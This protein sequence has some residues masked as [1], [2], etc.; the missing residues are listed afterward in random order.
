MLEKVKHILTFDKTVQ[1]VG[2]TFGATNAFR[3]LQVSHKENQLIYKELQS[4]NDEND[5]FEV[6]DKRKPVLLAFS[7]KGVLSKKMQRVPDYRSKVVMNVDVSEFYYYEWNGAKDVFV[8][9]CRK[10]VVNEH[11]ARFKKAGYLVVDYSIGPFVGAVLEPLIEEEKIPVLNSVL[12]FK[13]GVLNEVRKLQ[14]IA[15]LKMGD[16]DMSNQEVSLFATALNYYHGVAE[17]EYEQDFLGAAR[18]ENNYRKHFERLGVFVLVGFFVAL[19]AS[20]LLLGRYN[21][22]VAHQNISLSTVK[23]SV[24]QN[25]L[26]AKEVNEKRL[27]LGQSGVFSKHYLTYYVQELAEDVPS[28]MVLDELMIFPLEKKV[29]SGD[30]V[31]IQAETLVVKGKSRVNSVFNTWYRGV[32]KLGWIK[33][34]DIIN[35]TTSKKGGYNFEIKIQLQ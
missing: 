22:R 9:V 35:Y 8:S 2:V 4:F 24:Q 31:K 18:E 7:G 33:K 34:V 10:K 20:Y 6:L 3:L 16:K 17:L 19:L 23:M 26:L 32:K 25:T 15:V 14:E 29:K 28:T 27:I 30:P 5:L 11:V 13:Q 1:V 12:L 21:E